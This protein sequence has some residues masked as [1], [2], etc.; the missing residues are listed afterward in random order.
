MNV[1]LLVVQG[2]PAGKQLLFGQGE[3]YLGRGP[4]CQVRFNSDWV[5]RQHCVLTVGA[6]GATVRDLGS[7]NGTLVNG[8]LIREA[9]ALA[10]RDRVQ[11]GP[12]TFEVRIDSVTGGSDPEA[13]PLGE[14]SDAGM[15]STALLPPPEAEG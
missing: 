9:A 15:G 5:S 2:K 3:Y 4:E 13:V 8:K 1:K 7:R 12:V 6:G 14:G 11:V 10:D